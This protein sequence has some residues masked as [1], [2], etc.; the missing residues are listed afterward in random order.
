MDHYYRRPVYLQ[1]S[2]QLSGGKEVHSYSVSVGW[3]NTLQSI[4][5][6]KEDRLT[7]NFQNSWTLAEDRL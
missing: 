2:L 6:N 7:L 3:D 5:G 1:N 4:R